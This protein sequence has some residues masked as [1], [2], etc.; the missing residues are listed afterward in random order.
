MRTSFEMA[1]RGG[2]CPPYCADCSKM[3]GGMGKRTRLPVSFGCLTG[4]ST[5]PCHPLNRMAGVLLGVSEHF[6]L[7]VADLH[8]A[9]AAAELQEAEMPLSRAILQRRRG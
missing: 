5:C 8:V 1:G 6:D 2:Q 3:M 9:A 7:R 4:K